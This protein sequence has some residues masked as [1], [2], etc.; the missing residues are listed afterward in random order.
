MRRASR[1]RESGKKVAQRLRER[2]LEIEQAILTRVHAVSELPATGGPEYAEGLRAAVGAA[3]DYGLEG[4]ERG[5]EGASHP[6]DLLLAQA[7]LAARSG[8]SLD[9][10]LRRCFAGHTLLGDFLVQEAGRDLGPVGLNRLLRSQAAVVDRLFAAVARAYEE[11][12]ERRPRGIERRRAQIVERLLAG[13]LCDPSELAYDFAGWHLGVVA[14]GPGGREAI[15]GIAKE[16]ECRLLVVPWEEGFLW[17]WLG[18]RCV[19]DPA[20]LDR[21][22]PREPPSGLRLALGAPAEELPGWRLSH[23]QARAALSVALHGGQAMVRYPDV[24][25]LA[26]A[27]Q[28]RLLAASLQQLYLVPLERERDNGQSARRTLRAYFSSGRKVSSAAAVLGVT[29]QTVTNRIHAIEDRV[30][31]SLTA[32]GNDLEIALQL[33]DLSFSVRKEDPDLP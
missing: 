19:V 11:Q 21:A 29:R 6:P 17:A 5:E 25:L 32:C 3:V 31:R 10:V 8:V 26:S 23:L 2:R 7:R 22:I 14:F 15:D 33:Q 9:T 20:A 28:D 4:I 30:G 16:L 27:M 12:A 1:E 13:D 24:A 18:S